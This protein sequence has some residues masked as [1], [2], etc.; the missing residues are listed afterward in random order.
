MPSLYLYISLIIQQVG[1]G[2]E[3]GTSGQ[4]GEMR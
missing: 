2:K 4:V 1:S 3:Q